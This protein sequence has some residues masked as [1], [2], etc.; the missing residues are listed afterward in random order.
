MLIC[1]SHSMIYITM[2]KFQ[3]RL[4][5]RVLRK[6]GWSIKAIAAH[7]TV[8][9]ASASIW[10]RDLQ[11]TQAQRER[12]LRN[13]IKAGHKGR[14]RGALVNRERK[15]ERVRFHQEGGQRTIGEFSQRDLLIA[16]IALY[17][18]EG[19]RKSRLGFTNSEPQMIQFMA[20]WFQEVMGVQRE[21]FMP[22]I[23]IN[24]IHRPRIDKVLRFWSRLLQLP[25]RQF[26]N[27]VFLKRPP[28]KVYENY[29]SYH[30]VLALGVRRSNE[31]KY[32]ILGLIEAMR[33]HNIK[34]V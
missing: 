1:Y 16:G 29:E 5:A 23:F 31:L 4:E 34:P 2:A 33:D 25:I 22:R 12:L 8:S 15:E 17:W 24:A 9:K 11:L 30:G 13:A 14:M 7:L 3:K 32:Q 6:Q 10:C 18:A 27:P 19:T 28:R 20:R 21:D 26:G